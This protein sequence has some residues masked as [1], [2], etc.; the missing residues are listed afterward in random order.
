MTDEINNVELVNKLMNLPLFRDMDVHQ[1]NHILEASSKRELPV[2]EVLCHPM[3]IDERLAVLVDG[4]LRLESN[5]G[6]QLAEM[7]PFRVVGEMGVLTGQPRKTRVIAEKP[8]LV[9]MLEAAQLQSL[10]EHEPEI[11]THMQISLI[12]GLYERIGAMNDDIR[13]LKDQSMRFRTRLR[14]LAP[15]DPL[16]V[17]YTS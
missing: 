2:G 15:E 16:L 5:E 17:E 13:N 1:I 11:I 8:S 14:E 7:V 3:T 4:E 9:Y 12:K 10:L 6:E